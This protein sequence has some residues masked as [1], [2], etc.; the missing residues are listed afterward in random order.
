MLHLSTNETASNRLDN[1]QDV[2]GHIDEWQNLYGGFDREVTKE[3]AVVLHALAIQGVQHGMT[4]PVSCTGASVGLPALPKVQ[5][6]AAES[7]LVDFALICAREWQPIVLKLYD[8]LG[9]LSTHILD[10]VLRKGIPFVSP[11]G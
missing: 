7:S 8:S 6:L 10:G 5:R 4:S 3:L 2:V 1:P 9:R 11:P